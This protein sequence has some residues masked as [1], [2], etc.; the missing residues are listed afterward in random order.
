MNNSS[1]LKKITITNHQKKSSSIVILLLIFL[2]I[3][4]R[5]IWVIY[6][7]FTHEDAFITFQYT[8]NLAHGMG[9]VY[10]PGERVLGTTSPLY[11]LI[12]A[13]VEITT[14]QDIVDLAHIL[15]IL[16]SGISFILLNTF[17]RNVGW[18]NSQLF[19]VIL[20]YATA[21]KFWL[22]E[23]NGM[24]T[25]LVLALMVASLYAYSIR[26]PV[27]MG[28]LCG[29]LI[30][31][32]IDTV[33]W[34]LAL[35]LVAVR[36]DKPFVWRALL[37][38]SAIILPWVIFACIYFGSPIPHTIPAKWVA[39]PRFNFA[40]LHIDIRKLF[41][42]LNPYL[43][44]DETI[45]FIFSSLTLSAMSL[46]AYR[47]FRDPKI[48]VVILYIVLETFR[49]LIGRVT[50]FLRYM[51]PLLWAILLLAALGSGELLSQ[52]KTYKPT[53]KI[54]ALALAIAIITAGLLPIGGKLQDARDQQRL[55]HEGSLVQ[56][57]LWLNQNTPADS[58]VLLEPLGHVGYYAER[59]MIDEVGIITPE[60]TALK[61]QGILDPLEYARIFDVDYIVLHCDD[62]HKPQMLEPVDDGLNLD[63]YK[64]VAAFNPLDYDPTRPPDTIWDIDLA[65]RSCYDIW[66]HE[67]Q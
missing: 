33:V 5:L 61:M 45:K 42:F 53:Y 27:L 62:P 10:N 6:T 34:P 21:S 7:Q 52:L 19:A 50:V 23:T 11:A 30:W 29:L 17:G 31:T 63:Y 67:R 39:Y 37:A 43:I 44:E 14:G 51:T 9:F 49:I 58:R 47:R 46:Y 65:R 56:L 38:A 22:L 48:K 12:L 4:V 1:T 41:L 3:T 35:L 18:S 54:I 55:R 60:I 32:R 13:A 20:M 15:G 57:G 2:G 28:V 25:V 24:E 64:V 26:K 8:K 66:A 16:F 36:R 59:R 40:E